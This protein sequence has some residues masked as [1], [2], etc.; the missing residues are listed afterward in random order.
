MRTKV[1][2]VIGSLVF[3]AL[4]FVVQGNMEQVI[5]RK[6]REAIMTM[7]IHEDTFKA[8]NTR[9]AQGDETAFEEMVTELERV[10][11]ALSVMSEGD[12]EAFFAKQTALL[13]LRLLPLGILLFLVSLLI[14]FGAG[15]YYLILPILRLTDT[16]EAAKEARKFVFPM[17][18]LGVWIFLRSF[19][20][21]P[22]I[23]LFTGFYYL[24]RFAFS[25]VIL[26]RDKKG[27]R[28]SAKASFDQTTGMWKTITSYLLGLLLCLWIA[29]YAVSWLAD[30]AGDFSLF[31][32]DIFGQFEAA[33]IAV[34]LVLLSKK[35]LGVAKE[36]TPDA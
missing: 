6:A 29:S 25:G 23:G 20:W 3:G 19:V 10:T 31:V 27:I 4:L 8:L 16:V 18:G 14:S 32:M 11:E 24:P 28:E 21:V 26:I 36:K 30:F 5:D 15:A 33:F 35:V 12:Q 34:F 7:G 1:P 17:I 9:M 13:S 2:I 22:F